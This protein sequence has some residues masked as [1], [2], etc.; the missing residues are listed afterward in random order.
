MSPLYYYCNLQNPP[1]ETIRI[2]LEL[3]ADPN[4]TFRTAFSDKIPLTALQITV[5]K[6]NLKKFAYLVKQPKVPITL[7]NFVKA[8]VVY[9]LTKKNLMYFRKRNEVIEIS[10]DDINKS[11][12]PI[13][14]IECED[15][16]LIKK[17][18]AQDSEILRDTAY[19]DGCQFF[20]N[21]EYFQSLISFITSYYSCANGEEYLSEKPDILYK[22]GCCHMKLGNISM[23]TKLLKQQLEFAPQCHAAK[24]ADSKLKEI[25]SSKNSLSTTQAISFS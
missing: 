17:F 15:D 4:L 2:L 10:H 8:F 13:I 24:L 7:E 18:N 9:D 12:F 21:K 22:L 16:L 14:D 3:G 25:N 11:L 5:Q 1:L 23:A 6:N 19:S 20:N